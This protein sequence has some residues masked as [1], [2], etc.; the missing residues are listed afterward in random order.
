MSPIDLQNRASD[1]IKSLSTP[2]NDSP[3]PDISA[4]YNSNKT[5]NFYILEAIH[6]SLN[7]TKDTFSS[8][9]LQ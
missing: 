2:P 7:T 1:V 6:K 9:F 3:L 5:S 8:Q 4:M